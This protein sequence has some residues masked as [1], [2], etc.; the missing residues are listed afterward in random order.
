[1]V[2]KSSLMKAT[3]RLYA[4]GVSLIIVGLFLFLLFAVI[5]PMTLKVDT[6]HCPNFLNYGGACA[7]LYGEILPDFFRENWLVFA[8]LSILVAVFGAVIIAMS[9]INTMKRR[10]KA[11]E[12]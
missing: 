9:K 5:N 6:S 8:I 1:M 2:V 12:Q 4:A 11:M 7:R 10:R 3:T